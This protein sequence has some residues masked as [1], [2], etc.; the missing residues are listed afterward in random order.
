MNNKKEKTMNELGTNA[1]WGALQMRGEYLR[2]RCAEEVEEYMHLVTCVGPNL[3]S[4]YMVAIGQYEHRVYQLKLEI[5]RWQRRFTLRQQA[6]NRGEAPDPVMIEAL[7]DDEFK[8]YLQEI[9]KHQEMLKEAAR[10]MTLERL[11]DE[12]NIA[13]RMN[14]LKAAKKLHPDIN[15]DLPDN[16]K[17]LWAQIQRAYEEKDWQELAFLTGMVDDVVAGKKSVDP[18]SGLEM[19]RKEVVRLESRL[20]QATAKREALMCEQPYCWKELLEC[21]EDVV[22]RQ[23]TLKAEIEK[24]EEAVREYEKL[25]NDREAA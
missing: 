19:L 18:A 7:L 2:G 17:E 4:M 13:I 25:W 20:K 22:L 14:Y 21:E 16:A 23:D 5:S 12:E 1:E 9:R 11:S 10:N 15:P 8:E 3:K 6:L 24:L